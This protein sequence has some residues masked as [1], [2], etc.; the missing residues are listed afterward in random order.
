MPELLAIETSAESC[1]VALGGSNGV[2]QLFEHAPMRHAERLLPMI[3]SLLGE[4]GLRLSEL[5]AIA[6]GRGPGSFT[7][8]RIGIGVVQ[9]LAWGAQLPVVP[10]SSLAAAAQA[11]TE[12]GK[13]SGA[14][15]VALDARMNE[16]YWSEFRLA[17]SGCVEPA[18]DEHVSSADH[19]LARLQHDDWHAVGNGFERFPQLADAAIRARSVH[20]DTWP[21]ARAVC[22]LAM[23]NWSEQRGLPAAKAQPVYLRNDVAEKPS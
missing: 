2:E 11:A 17:A 3:E 19:L 12:S 1:S 4:S 22:R 10:V 9:G 20:A 6:F 13:L 21:S 15:V 7:S 8:L 18:G 5:D 16:V 23:E 14:I